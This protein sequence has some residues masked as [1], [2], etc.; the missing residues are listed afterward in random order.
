MYTYFG[1]N[2]WQ[3]KRRNYVEYTC[4][5]RI[6]RE[7]IRSVNSREKLDDFWTRCGMGY[8]IYYCDASRKVHIWLCGYQFAAQL[9]YHRHRTAHTQKC[10]QSIPKPETQT[11]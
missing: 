8:R 10:S 1:F 5:K 11:M 3:Q 4:Y 6:K 9:Q 7:I 2:V